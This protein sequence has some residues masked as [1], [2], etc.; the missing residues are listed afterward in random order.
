MPGIARHIEFERADAELLGVTRNFLDLLFG[1]DLW[2][3]HGVDIAALVHCLA[4]SGQVVEIGIFEAAQENSD[5]GHAAEDRRTRLG[6]G[7]AFVGLFVANVDVRVENPGQHRA[8]GGVVGF[9]ARFLQV[10]AD[11]RDLAVG[12]PHVGL[13]LTDAGDD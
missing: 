3:K 5:A 6:L 2:V 13:D 12:D 8:P 4:E 10:F 11:H 9:R 1:E 7:F